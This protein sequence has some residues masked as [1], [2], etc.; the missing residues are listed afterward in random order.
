MAVS[1]EEF[2]GPLNEAFDKVREI[3]GQI[4]DKFNAGVKHINDW[5]FVLGPLMIPI[6][7]GLNKVSEGLSKLYKLIVYA[8]EHQVPIVALVYQSFNWVDG[9]QRP[10]NGV[11]TQQG[12]AAGQPPAYHNEDL[13]DWQGAAKTV[14]DSKVS[15]QRSAISAMETKADNISKWLMGIA[16]ANVDYMLELAK[17]A[18]GFLGALTTAAIDAASVVDIPFS[19]DKLSG[20]IGNL[21]TGGLNLLVDIAN[22]FM[23]TLGQIR[24]TDS[25]MN[26]N[27]LPAG[28]WPQAVYPQGA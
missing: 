10:L 7:D 24:D 22:R 27:A 3:I 17:L 8:L 4:I 28:H 21:V 23:Q 2:T 5:S 19:V 9:V 20:A 13:A 25:W 14:Y 12:P 18:T 1:P 11:Y 26:D 6:S 15:D 16:Q